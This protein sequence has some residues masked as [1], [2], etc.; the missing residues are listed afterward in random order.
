MNSSFLIQAHAQTQ[1]DS[2]PDDTPR[3]DPDQ[4]YKLPPGQ[5]E[6]KVQG[7]ASKRRKT[8]YHQQ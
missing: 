4:L 1:T 3:F 7:W 6:S 2:D 5:S 8:S